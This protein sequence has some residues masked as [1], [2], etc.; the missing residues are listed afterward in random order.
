[1]L[2]M[3]SV[4]GAQ[5]V[6][7]RIACTLVG[8]HVMNSGAVTR[9]LGNAAVICGGHHGA[10]VTS[11]RDGC[12][13]SRHVAPVGELDMRIR[14]WGREDEARVGRGRGGGGGDY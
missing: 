4:C 6:S 13:L 14:R 7:L 10:R 3:L 1:M 11:E 2:V 12:A 5:G 9:L 8:K